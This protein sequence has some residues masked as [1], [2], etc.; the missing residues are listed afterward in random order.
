MR[1]ALVV[2]LLL[3][4]GYGGAC[5]YLWTKQRELIFFPSRDVQRTPADLGL[6]YE[7]VLL[8][9]GSTPP[10][11]LHGWWLAAAEG[12]PAILYLHGNDLNIASDND[13]DRVARLN[14]MGFSV[15]S[16][17]YRGYGRSEGAFPSEAQVYADAE[18]A[19]TY[20]LKERRVEAK[21]A[22]IYGHSLGGAIALDLAVRHPDAAGVI[23]ESGFT[24]IPDV[25]R[26]VYWIFPTDLLVNQ[27]FDAL[28]R[29]A[30]L[31]VPVLFIHG[32]ADADVPYGMSE[33]LYAA[34]REPKRLT[35][36]AGAGHEDS[37]RTDEAGYRRAVLDFVLS[38]GPR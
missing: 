19:W 23:V 4:L 7:E 33:R 13:L 22:F 35:L 11:R 6:R 29:V 24:S 12:A 5:A 26:R 34:A 30:R 25:A 20:M 37:A 27:R 1:I 32:T 15:L 10:S 14:R 38:I 16:V 28:A 17:D 2:M 3:A 9:V 8:S 18:A 21:R 36:V 31:Q